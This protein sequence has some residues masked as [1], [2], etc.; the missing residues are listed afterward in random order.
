MAQPLD[1]G[2]IVGDIYINGKLELRG[3]RL[4]VTPSFRPEVILRTIDV[5]AP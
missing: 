1:A 5:A 4:P 3:L 2:D